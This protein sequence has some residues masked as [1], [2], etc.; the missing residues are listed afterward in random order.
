MNEQLGNLL[1]LTGKSSE[2]FLFEELYIARMNHEIQQIW[3]FL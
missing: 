1:F 2:V 3:R